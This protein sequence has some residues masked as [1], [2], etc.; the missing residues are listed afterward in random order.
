M[1]AHRTT[2]YPCIFQT[3]ELLVSS[4]GAN[5]TGTLFGL[6]VAGAG[7]GVALFAS[8]GAD[9]KSSTGTDMVTSLFGK[10]RSLFAAETAVVCEGSAPS[11]SAFVFIKPHVG[12]CFIPL[13]YLHSRGP[14]SS[15]QQPPSSF[16]PPSLTFFRLVLLVR[17]DS[18]VTRGRDVI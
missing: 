3:N 8:Y 15:P 18:V 16:Y 1:T 10:V 2:L 6:A 14:L 4:T 5:N 13:S 17:A 9:E 7:T 12:A 11:N